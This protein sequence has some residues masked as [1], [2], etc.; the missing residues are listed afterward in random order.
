M[1]PALEAVL[2]LPSD[3]EAERSSVAGEWVR[4][5]VLENQ[6]REDIDELRARAMVASKRRLH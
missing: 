1:D 2:D 6:D 4:R 5:R 3:W